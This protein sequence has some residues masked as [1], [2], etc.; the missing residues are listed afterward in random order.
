[1]GDNGF[2]L[3]EHGLFNKQTAYEESIRVP[4]IAMGGDISPK[5]VIDEFI[6]NIDIGPTILDLCG[7]AVPESMDG[8]SF[9]NLLYQKPTN[10]RDT[11]Y[12]EF[13]RINHYHLP[14]T[15]AVR[16][17]TFKYIHYNYNTYDR[18]HDNLNELYNIKNDPLEMNNL[19]RN[20]EY[21]KTVND[22]KKA[23]SD[24]LITTGGEAF[25]YK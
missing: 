23:I 25:H 14:A 11:I 18:V 10:W 16:T 12:Y 17:S 21:K 9:K 2:A 24:W 19:I 6:M 4:L 13:A 8:A 15:Y 22:F 20:P 1:M 5:T 7:I 3:G